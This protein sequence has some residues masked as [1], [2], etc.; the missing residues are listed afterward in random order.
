QGLA[1]HR[2][3]VQRQPRDE[4]PVRR[5]AEAPRG[6]PAQGAR[7]AGAKAAA[8][9]KGSQRMKTLKISVADDVYQR[10]SQKAAAEQA[11]LPEV[12]QDLLSAWTEEA[13][14]PRAAATDRGRTD[15]LKFL[16]ELATRP[17]KPGPSVGRLNREE[18]YR[19]GVP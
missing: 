17:L 1:A 10:G 15:F 4:G 8:V 16:D 5:G 9:S 7:A 12:V 13:R 11:S 2:W 19:R 14:P 3:A 6:R 18:L